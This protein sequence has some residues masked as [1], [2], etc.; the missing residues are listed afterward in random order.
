MSFFAIIAVAAI[1]G[2]VALLVK[3]NQFRSSGVVAIVVGVAVVG[4][5]RYRTVEQKGAVRLQRDRQVAATIQRQQMGAAVQNAAA[6]APSVIRAPEP[7]EEVG[8]VVARQPEFPPVGD[9]VAEEFLSAPGDRAAIASD[10]S[11]SDSP[12]TWLKLASGKQPDGRY[13]VVVSAQG[14]DVE[15][16][17]LE[18]RMWHIPS[19]VRSYAITEIG[20]R[21]PVPSLDG[22]A[23]E[24]FIS[25]SYVESRHIYTDRDG[26]RS[27]HKVYA[28]LDIPPTLRESLLVRR[29][30]DLIDA[31]LLYTSLAAALAL[32]MLVVVFAYFKVD[33]A[34]YGQFSRRLQVGAGL[35]L[36]GLAFSVV[37]LAAFAISEEVLFGGLLAII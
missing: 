29:H 6:A 2:F 33:D 25:D 14:W 26:P 19:A 5:W 24:S 18:I 4:I 9:S 10:D 20:G 1:A 28:L 13:R 35:L 16:C 32:G 3:Q 31:R 34:T 12:P 23:A 15:Q 36:V 22:E 21:W 7:A 30:A 27:R 8:P 37:A 11:H 17:W